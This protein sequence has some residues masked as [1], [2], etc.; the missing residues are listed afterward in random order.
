M[1]IFFSVEKHNQLTKGEIR[2]YNTKTK[3]R[4]KRNIFFMNQNVKCNNC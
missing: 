4:K 1:W 3:V 2:I